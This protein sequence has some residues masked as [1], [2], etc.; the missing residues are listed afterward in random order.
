MTKRLLILVSVLIALGTAT[1]YAWWSTSGTGTASAGV[2]TL[3]APGAPT[4]A[5]TGSAVNLSW[6]PAT[7][8]GGGTISY[9][10]E[11]STDPVT[12]WSD[13][14]GTTAGSGTIATSCTDTPATGT[15][16]YRATAIFNSWT[17]EGAV[18][19]AFVAAS[20]DTTAPT[21]TINQAGGQADP[22]N[23]S[24]INFT[25]VFSEPVTGFAGGDVTLTGTAGATT[26]VVTGA[27]RHDLQRRRQRHD[28][29]RHGDRHDRRRRGA[30]TR[31]GNANAASTSTDNTVTYDTIAPTVTINQAAGQA[32]P[33]N[34]SPDQLHG[35][36]Q[37]GGHRLR[38]RRRHARRHA[39][40]RTTGDRDRQ[41]HDLQRGGQRHDRQ[42]HR[43]RHDR[44]RRRA[45]RGG[46]QQHGLDQHR[47][48]G[49]LRHDRAR[50]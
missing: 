25:V 47:Q 34:S 7:V 15:Y 19:D 24:P 50:R 11:R 23:A 17:A 35:R 45:R 49:H 41:R 14:C 33:T 22:T 37:R 13:A 44:R 30:A 29:R 32:D 2:G 3:T 36:V 9:H 39:P 4:R 26:A 10:L 46:Q 12:T 28:R 48:H 20:A 6:T 31:A 16:R 27:R 1:A 42:R 21:V 38:H 8:S 40:A 5:G 18:S 43:H